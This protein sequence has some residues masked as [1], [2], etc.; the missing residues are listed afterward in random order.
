MKISLSWL[1]DFIDVSEYLE[2]P[3]ELADKLTAAGLEV[4]GVERIGQF[5]NL[6]VGKIAELKKHPDADKLTV[7]QVDVGVDVDTGE[8]QLRQIVCGATNH[9]QGDKVC[10]ALPGCVLPGDFKIKKSKIRGQESL[11]MLCSDSELGLSNESE[12]IRILDAQAPVGEDVAIYLNLKDSLLEISVTPNRADCLSHW[13]LARE[14]SCLLGRPL[15]ALDLKSKDQGEKLPISLEV[16]NTQACPRFTGR[17]LSDVEV[18]ESPAWLKARL[19]KCGI[20]S[21]NNVVD[22]TNYVMLELGQPMHAYDAK[23]IEGG[24]VLV[25]NSHKGEVFTSFDGSEFVLTGEELCIRDGKKVVGLAGVVGS[26]NSGIKDDTK[27]VFLECAYFLPSQVRKTS[28]RFGIETDAGY[29]FARGT[30]AEMVREASLR[31]CEL[32]M[33]VAGAKVVSELVDF[34]PQPIQ[35]EEIKIKISDITERLGFTAQADKFETWLERLFCKYKKQGD[36][37]SVIPPSFR[38]DFFCKEDLIEEYGRLEGYD[39]IPEILPAMEIFP[40]SQDP[41]FTH[42]KVLSEHMAAL[43]YSQSYNYNFFSSE[44]EKK[45]AGNISSWTQWSIGHNHESVR[46]KN[47]L[48]E[49]LDVMR[50]L[51]APQ[52]F[53]NALHNWKY[54]RAWGQLFEVGSVFYKQ[55]SEYKEEPRLAAIYWGEPEQYW[56]DIKDTASWPVFKL[57]ASLENLFKKI[58][59][60]SYKFENI[61]EMPTDLNFYHP[62]QCAKVIVQGKTVGVLGSLHPGLLE[63]SKFR[64]PAAYFELNSSALFLGYP[65]YSKAKP[66]VYY[67][68]VERDMTFELSKDIEFSELSQVLN[69]AVGKNLI[70]VELKDIYQGERLE[71]GQHAITVSLRLQDANKSI[72]EKTLDQIQ[73]NIFKAVELRFKSKNLKVRGD[74]V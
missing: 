13:G 24:K 60:T 54:G 25:E 38:Y 29:R 74:D 65:R 3:Q 19:E 36:V 6:K 16:K 44:S 34:Y 43:G 69:K 15:K 59:I 33:E 26:K 39:Q 10:V 66:L 72:E 32:L 56:V 5:E 1:N 73:K 8:A 48:N 61:T 7:C 9:R 55:E 47:P 45:I 11:G 62:K 37:Y 64:V 17:W 67:P 2:N 12:G 28:R 51:L 53:Q 46:L 49:N 41:S 27:E 18:K 20:N 42:M 31:A 50:S 70:S 4:E 21:V 68:I 52:L 23:F 30:D 35:N 71:E 14:V 40:T 57:K 58:G 22:V 63:T